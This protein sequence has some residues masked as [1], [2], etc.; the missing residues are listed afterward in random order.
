MSLPNAFS[1]FFVSELFKYY[2]NIIEFIPN[3]FQYIEIKNLKYFYNNHYYI[4]KLKKNNTSVSFSYLN[5]PILSL[6][7]KL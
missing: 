1:L 7:I 2:F 4:H 3:E 5:I 6:N